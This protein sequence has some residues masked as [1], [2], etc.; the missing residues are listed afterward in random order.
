MSE[1]IVLQKTHNGMCPGPQR[2]ACEYGRENCELQSERVVQG[3]FKLGRT[4]GRMFGASLHTGACMSV[5]KARSNHGLAPSSQETV[6]G[7][8]SQQRKVR[9]WQQTQ[10]LDKLTVV[11]L[12]EFSI[13]SVY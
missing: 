11:N 6:K 4:F 10:V 5:S 8:S 13:L 7:S 1:G 9:Q 3:D 2:F 12:R